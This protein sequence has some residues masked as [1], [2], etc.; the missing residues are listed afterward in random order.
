M[1][2]FQLA[3]WRERPLGLL[4]PQKHAQSGL[5]PQGLQV[6]QAEEHQN[7]QENALVIVRREAGVQDVKFEFEV[8]SYQDWQ[9]HWQEG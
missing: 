5:R 9:V 1:S 3:E 2:H 7:Q 6:D 8:K 4:V